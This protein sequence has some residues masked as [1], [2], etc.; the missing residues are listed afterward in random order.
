[1][2]AN[3]AIRKQTGTQ[4]DRRAAILDVAAEL[5]ARDGFSAVS[6]RDL[7]REVGLTPAALYYHFPD[8][9][10]LYTEVLR[11]VFSDKTANAVDILNTGKEPLDLL[12]DLI[13]YSLDVFVLDPVLSRLLRR[14]LLDGN[15]ERIRFF[16]DEFGR[17]PYAALT[18]VM[19][20][21]APD[22]DP[23]LSATSVMGLILGH[24]ELTPLHL[25]LCR[26]HNPKTHQKALARHIR[27]VLLD[28]LKP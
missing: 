15:D 6:M 21:L 25:Q 24:V 5:F 16:A 11:S 18:E 19:Q 23:E 8:K 2:T 17:G 26:N 13:A 12:D 28:G 20:R 22:M 4:K 10:T 9:E 1:M 14:E 27:Q 7:A 3:T